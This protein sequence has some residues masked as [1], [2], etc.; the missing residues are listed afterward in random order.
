ML[1]DHSFGFPRLPPCDVP[2]PVSG[3]PEQEL[4]VL[5]DN[6]VVVLSQ[7]LQILPEPPLLTVTSRVHEYHHPPAFHLFSVPKPV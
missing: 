7:V 6:D 3:D 4:E 2:C 5:T 1:H